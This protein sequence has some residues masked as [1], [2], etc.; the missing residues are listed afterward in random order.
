[1]MP[2]SMSEV[3]RYVVLMAFLSQASRMKWNRTL[4]CLVRS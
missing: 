3:D 4:M 2:A 1:M